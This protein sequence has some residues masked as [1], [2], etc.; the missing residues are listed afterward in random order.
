MSETSSVEEILGKA[1]EEE[2]RYEWLKAADCYQKA[3]MAVAETDLLRKGEICE[4]I[5]YAIYKAAFQVEHS[6]EFKERIG[7]ALTCYG[8]AKILYEISA[9]TEKSP[10]IFR[11]NAMIAFA[12]YWLASE[13]TEK[14]RLLDECWQLTKDSLSSMKDSGKTHEYGRTYNQL[15]RSTIFKFFLDWKFETRKTSTM[16]ALEHGEQAINL[17]SPLGNPRELARTYAETAACLGMFGYYF[18][19]LDEKEIDFQKAKT[20][21]LRARELDEEAALLELLYPVFGPHLALWGEATEEAFANLE[22]ALDYSKK[23][24]DKFTI[25]AA[26]D[27]LA[28]H[29]AWSLNT[30]DDE[31]VSQKTIEKLLQ[32]ATDARRYYSVISFISPRADGA[33]TGTAHSEFIP[34][35]KRETDQG[36]KRSMLEKAVEILREGFRLA[37]LSGYPDVI[38]HVHACLSYRLWQL[39][40]IGTDSE[41][42]KK[43]LEESLQHGKEYVRFVKQFRPLEYWDNGI[44]LVSLA[45]AGHALSEL[46]DDDP[47]TTKSR[48]Q[49]AIVDGEKGIE[50]MIRALTVVGKRSPVLFG[51]L[52]E[53]QFL[54]GVWLTLFYRLS[55]EEE[56]LRKSTAFFGDAIISFRR[57]QRTT[58]VAE[59]YWNAAR[60]YDT[61]CEYTKAAESF[62][63]ASENYNTAA[64]KIP[65]SKNSMETI[66]STCEL[67][68]K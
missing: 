9:D 68:A 54:E 18:A 21:W 39:A 40:G 65:S 50:L 38:W 34:G 2:G 15:F 36:K 24:R 4:N 66:R 1:K 19:D 16:E 23:N 35:Y 14:K 51:E 47:E 5:A 20:Y 37:E 56:H 43:L 46:P 27:W 28:Y 31:D 33:W 59:C 58:R 22:K 41:G 3:L 32:N 26:L 67:G 8:E 30:I 29:T 63:L 60:S 55:N 49:Q 57:I 7:Q 44:A 62:S 52:G 61:L 12:G 53:F 10:K 6:H 25:G 64:S 45:Q 13:P 11:C 48:F 42:R 17:L